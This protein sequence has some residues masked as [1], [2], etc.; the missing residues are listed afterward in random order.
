MKQEKVKSI[1]LIGRRWFQRTYGNTYHS[2]EIV[3]NGRPLHKINYK[4]GYGQHYIQS[5]FDWLF[6]KSVLTP[7]KRTESNTR[8]F[9]WAYC[10]KHNITFSTSCTEVA[11]KKDL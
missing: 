11:R 1:V 8:L 5:A 9:G 3:V 2:V 10:D 7:T 6:D 4:Y